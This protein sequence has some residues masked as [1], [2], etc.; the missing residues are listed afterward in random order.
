MR[1]VLVVLFSL[2][3]LV[4]WRGLAS[5]TDPTG[6]LRTP[7]I[8]HSA[9][10]LLSGRVLVVGGDVGSALA[11]AEIYDSGTGSWE[12]TD[13]LD[14]PRFRHTATLLPSGRV[15]VAGGKHYSS[16]AWVEIYDPRTGTWERAAS[17]ATPRARHTATLLPSGKVLIVGGEDDD[18]NSFLRSAEIFDPAA[19]AWESTADLGVARARHTATLLRSGKVLVVGGEGVEG[20][21]TSAELYD[22][23]TGSWESIGDL[24]AA[25]SRHTTTLLASGKVLIA[26]GED[27]GSLSSA[28]LFDPSTG[29][30][31]STDSLATARSRHSATLLPSGKLLLAGGKDGES[32]SS[33]EI[34]DPS[35]ETWESTGPLAIPRGGH[36]ATLLAS[37][38]ILLAG[39]GNGVDGPL[40]SAESYD[41]PSAGFWERTEDLATA[42][43]G[44]TA[45]LLASG[46]VLVTGGYDGSALSSA[47][48]YD[49]GTGSWADAGPLTKAR[50]GHTATLLVSGKVL[51]AGRGEDDAV[52]GAELYDPGT[53][54]WASTGPLVTLG[55]GHSA[56]LLPSGKVLVAGG[57]R[58]TYL[59]IAEVYDPSTGSWESTDELNMRRT[60]HT[61]T[62]LVSGKVLVAGGYDGASLDVAETYD[63]RAESW[64]L[65]GSLATPRRYH[66]ATLLPSGKVLV[67]GGLNE[68][69]ALSSVEIYDP[70]MGSWEFTGSLATA[71]FYHS[72]TLLLSGEVL[73]AGGNNA[74]TDGDDDIAL[75]SVE[76]YD[77]STGSWKI[78]DDLEQKRFHHTAGLLRSGRVLV[79]SGATGTSTSPKAEI[80]DPTTAAEFRRPIIQSTPQSISHGEKFHVTGAH[81]RGIS[82]AGS[83]NTSSSAVNYPLVQLRTLDGSQHTWL[84]PDP[85]VSFWDDPITLEF[86]DLP[87][88]LNPGHH[89]LTVVTAGVAS[90]PVGVTFECSLDITDPEDQTAGIGSTAT[91]TVDTQGGRFFQWQI[92]GVDIPG[93]TGPSYTTPPILGPESGTSF[94]VKVDSG[95][96]SKT[97][98]RATLTV[99]DE[100]AP[101]ARVDSPSGG[102]YWLLSDTDGAPRTELIAW[103]MSDNVRICRVRALLL[104]SNDGGKSYQKAPAGGGLP[105]TFGRRGLCRSPGEAT[106]SLEYT[107]PG[108]PPS[109]SSG[110]LYKIELRV[111][112]HAGQVTRVRSP[113]PFFIVRPNPD[114]VR[115]LI[116]TNLPRMKSK[117]GLAAAQTEALSI[118]LRELTDHPRVQGLIVDLDGVTSLRKLYKAWDQNPGSI[119]H[120][121]RVLFGP[122]GLHEHLLDLLGAFTGVENLILVGDDRILPMARVKDRTVLL[123]ESSYTSDSL[124]DVNASLT[125]EGTTVGRALAQ[126]QYLTDDPLVTLADVAPE[127]L[128]EE[129]ALFLPDLAVGR[130]VE[131]PEE[132][133]TAIATFISQDG[134]LDLTVLDSEDGHRTLVS[135]YDFLIDSAKSIRRR[136][137]NAFGLPQP[138]EDLAL[139]PV[140]GQLISRDWGESSVDARR[141]ALWT[142]LAGNGGEHYGVVNPNGH[143]THH[144]SGVPGIDRLDI[145]GLRAA[146]LSQ[147]DLSGSVV[148]AVGCH[149]GLPVAGSEDPADHP[150]DLPQTMLARGVVGYLAN[151][152][153]GW[154][155]LNGVG[156]SERLVEI[157]T[158]ELTSGGTVVLGDAYRR[159]KD[160]YFLESPRIDDY[161]RKT[162]MQWAFYGFPMYAVKTG[163]AAEE[164]AVTGPVVIERRIS[165][166]K[167]APGAPDPE[168]PPFLTRVEQRFDFTAE[169]VYRKHTAAGDVVPEGVV[170]CPEPSEGGAEGCYYSLNGLATGNADLPIEP[171]FVYDSRLSGTSLHGVLWRGGSWEEEAGWKPIFA[172][173][174]S[175]GGDGSVHGSTPR[176]IRY[177]PK[178]PRRRGKKSP[179]DDAE[180]CRPSDLDLTSVVFVAGET[181]KAPEGN[182]FSRHRLD[183]TVELEVLYFNDT[184]TG[185]GNC[186]RQGPLFGDGPYHEVRGTGIEWAVPASDE[187]GVWRVVVVYTDETPDPS[188][189]G[190]WRPLDLADD[191]DGVWRGR[192]QL[193]GEAR[194]TY[195]LQAVD[196]RG[197]VS[198]LLYEPPEEPASGVEQGIPLPVEVAVVP[199][200]ADLAVDITVE[201]DPVR[202]GAPL[203][204]TIEVDNLGPDAAR[205]VSV[206][207]SL[208]EP[209]TYVFGGGEGWICAE[210][211]G[212]RACARES[213]GMGRNS[214][215]SVTVLAPTNAG[216][217]TAY[218]VAGHGD[219]DPVTANNSGS[220]TSRV[221]R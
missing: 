124:A 38:K 185:V 213:L 197:N 200:T 40:S 103:S 148:Y 73:V 19:E 23:T 169:G 9:T 82:E 3:E 120:S 32:S 178:G 49:P 184:E 219:T 100:E 168:L 203:L 122:G 109:G 106:T 191:G 29:S 154:G 210:T 182:F 143:A 114:S 196:R 132:I 7:R 209:V 201:P 53:G 160:R 173:L 167:A 31:A 90:E 71:R 163:I 16:L 91:F 18:S 113:N 98:D 137:K 27:G 46:K 193:A 116:L 61:A 54:S 164:K 130:L 39:G 64:E 145:Q 107:V 87:P 66:T 117:M 84:V 190:S 83:G 104:L 188:G 77:P 177:R 150:V 78:V 70:S 62:L 99:E 214:S 21:L 41:P 48:I 176:M 202:F 51:L 198:W 65:T 208:P 204:Y 105:A 221:N 60:R 151:T 170:G 63:P 174:A 95:C 126:D 5:A 72:A 187:A 162:L 80:Y 102:E 108:E 37:G 4:V 79:V 81:F 138:H 127:D 1:R 165:G 215:I 44:R 110:S 119:P 218:V 183:R 59:S 139:A 140:D 50:S 68:L 88:T 22:P 175:N 155:L 97:S 92:D 147:I 123:L 55:D 36:T 85:P 149:G 26:G 33:L 152:G 12:G 15:L 189:R 69:G 133:I 45:T 58:G 181:L 115:T 35:T 47:E 24:A 206:T 57:L 166:G 43:D 28:E 128:Q 192:L 11:S 205:A 76:I 220:V 17:L 101:K 14:I 8:E 10:L 199:G 89:L 96:D 144:E 136:W 67:A 30:W 52:S 172:E 217:L 86:S 158:A 135:G 195:Y 118:K 171:L 94:R 93:A 25:R 129:G 56:T 142:H 159:A 212:D 153:Y 125:T 42:G 161:D 74:D 20:S 134:V 121:N 179:L 146:D 180:S 211:Q 13:P 194:L 156:L 34:Y 207:L 141:T 131:T 2:M 157:F 186:D 111:T 6:F 75:S 216:T 112:D